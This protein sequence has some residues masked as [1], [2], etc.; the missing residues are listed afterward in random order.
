MKAARQGRELGSSRE[1]EVL[2]LVVPRDREDASVQGT[3]LLEE[4]RT[5]VCSRSR[6]E[7][8]VTSQQRV[9]GQ[10]RR[11]KELTKVAGAAARALIANHAPCAIAIGRV[12][13]VN[14]LRKT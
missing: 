6:A 9:F 5:H 7:G 3:K 2:V 13:N 12:R 11:N 10:A 1:R 4:G 14:V 8:E